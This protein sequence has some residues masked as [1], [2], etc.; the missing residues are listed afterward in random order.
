MIPSFESARQAR[1]S[2]WSL[3]R[4]WGSTSR[5][6]W[7][8]LSSDWH[9][10]RFTR[11]RWA[12]VNYK[13]CQPSLFSRRGYNRVFDSFGNDL[14]T[15]LLASHG[16]ESYRVSRKDLTWGQPAGDAGGAPFSAEL[17]RGLPLGFSRVARSSLRG[18]T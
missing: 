3:L 7:R 14:A 8:H 18:R 15:F 13:V 17:L 16:A 6:D 2:S 12:R 11:G 4:N 9:L 5:A 1:H 10:G